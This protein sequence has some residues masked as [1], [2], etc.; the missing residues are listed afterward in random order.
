M[1]GNIEKGNEET[2]SEGNIDQ[3]KADYEGDQT[4]SIGSDKG[5]ENTEG[6]PAQTRK[7]DHSAMNVSPV[8]GI[9]NP[10]RK[11]SA[12]TED[13]VGARKEDQRDMVY[14]Q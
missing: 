14:K 4:I 12:L 3:S 5:V 8:K 13:S 2:N 9:E 6:N 10:M 11:D 1:E 7:E